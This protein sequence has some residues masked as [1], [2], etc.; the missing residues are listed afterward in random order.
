MNTDPSLDWVYRAVFGIPQTEYQQR[1]ADPPPD[2]EPE[3]PPDD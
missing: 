1:L 2:V 3:A